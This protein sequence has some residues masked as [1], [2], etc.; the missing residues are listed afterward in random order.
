MAQ[1]RNGTPPVDP[2]Y[3]RPHFALFLTFLKLLSRVQGRM[4]D[5]TRRH[6]EYYYREVLRLAPRQAVADRVPVIVELRPGSGD[7]LLSKGTL[8]LA[9]RDPNEEDVLYQ[10]EA[11]LVANRA[12]IGSVKSVFAKQSV[13]GLAQVCKDVDISG[14]DNRYLALLKM[15]LGTPNPGDDV[16]PL[17]GLGANPTDAAL[18]TGNLLTDLD[19]LL[20]FI[21]EQLHMSVSTFRSLMKKKRDLFP[22]AADWKVVN[23][24]LLKVGLAKNDKFVLPRPQPTN[25]ADFLENLNAACR[26]NLASYAGLPEVKDVFALYRHRNGRDDVRLFVKNTLGMTLEDD[27]T[28]RS[29]VTMMIRIEGMYQKWRQIADILRVA[30]RRKQHKIAAHK[31]KASDLRTSPVGDP[32][33]VDKFAELVSNNL[34]TIANWPKVNGRTIQNFDDVDAALRALEAGLSMSAEEYSESR[35]IIRR[36]TSDRVW[37]DDE[38]PRGAAPQGNWQWVSK[39]SAPVLSGTKSFTTGANQ[40]GASQVFFQNATSA[41]PVGAGDSLFAHV[42]LDP[43]NPPREIMLQWNDG[44]WE[45]RAF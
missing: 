7:L 33:P 23:D 34:G 43:G 14:P 25:L 4:N 9:G 39:P 22:A 26:L 21:P 44:S 13:T 27:G 42:Y 41:L 24:I 6:L 5:L 29:F 12:S 8:L 11:D 18:V 19:S 35:D 28:G 31:L 17:K 45:H 30:G 3:A 1:P 20:R 37:I 32:V 16:P 40:T 2:R 15:A 10:T 36:D 38:L